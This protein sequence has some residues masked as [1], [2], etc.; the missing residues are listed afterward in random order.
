MRKAS[1]AGKCVL[2][3]G[4]ARRIGAAIVR[5]LHGAGYR[6]VV[7]FHE[8]LEAAVDL[9][10]ELNRLRPRSV[11]ILQADLTESGHLVEIAG[12]AIA[13]FGRLDGLI[14]NASAFYPTPVDTVSETHWEELVGCNLR[15]PYFLSLALARELGQRAGSIINITDIHGFRPL[16]SFS[17]YSISKAGLNAMTQSLAR[18]LA[19][20]VRVNAVAPGA[21]LWPENQMAEAQQERILAKIALGRTGAPE[22]VAEA[23]LFLLN[24]RYITGHVLPVDGGRGLYA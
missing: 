14:N 12:R 16:K 6:V 3:T 21:I 22:D 15:A 4:G 23:V 11:E 20:S 17:L 18:E 1:Q 5:E 8:S 13:S 2:V 9:K 19:P 10:N 24:S 7:H